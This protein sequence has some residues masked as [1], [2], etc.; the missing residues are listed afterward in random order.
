MNEIMYDLNTFAICLCLL[1]TML[2]TIEFGYRA[3][4]R[5]ATKRGSHTHNSAIQNSVL[6]ILALLL[7]FTFSLSLQRFDNR[8]R[9]VV[10]EANAI[11]TTWLRAGLLTPA[12]REP[13]RDLLA[14]YVDLRVDASST[15][16]ALTEQRGPL[17]A[18]AE[19]MRQQLWAIGIAAV[20]ADDRPT[21]TGL[22]L[23]AL[24]DMID[25]WGV[26]EAALN[27]HVPEVVLFLLFGTFAIAAWLLGY[28]PGVEGHRP[29]FA[30]FL[31]TALI[32]V[33]VFIVMD[34]DR[35]RR[36]FIEVSQASLLELQAAVRAD[37]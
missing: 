34:L 14:E 15:N 1:A 18:Q 36:G 19:A 9:A 29:P 37:R 25:A 12:L 32:V 3:G 26:R 16:L 33:L 28:G 17:L 31:M 10:D 5:R 6:G 35:P 21:T 24:N 23:Q 4:N 22:Y 27:Q 13:A 8:S 2:V 11:G 30:S 20:S 7:A